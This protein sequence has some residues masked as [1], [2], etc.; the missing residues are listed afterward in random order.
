MRFVTDNTDDYREEHLFIECDDK[1]DWEICPNHEVVLASTELARGIATTAHPP[2]EVVSTKVCDDAVNNVSK[3]SDL[4]HK[5]ANLQETVALII[6][7]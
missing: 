7:C 4:L 5:E 6:E 3:W 2:N 1:D